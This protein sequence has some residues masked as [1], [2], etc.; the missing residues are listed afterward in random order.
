MASLEHGT[1]AVLNAA[2]STDG[3]ATFEDADLES[4]AGEPVAR[5][6]RLA[7][8]PAEGGAPSR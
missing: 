3:V 7:V 1:R 8:S 4:I 2:L 6:L 5:V